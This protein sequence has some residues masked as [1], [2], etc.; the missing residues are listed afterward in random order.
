MKKLLLILLIIFVPTT[1]FGAKV[2]IT[3]FEWQTVV[4]DQ[5]FTG[6]ADTPAISTATFNG[7]LASLRFLTLS[8]GTGRYMQQQFRAADAD[9]AFVKFA[10]RIVTAPSAATRIANIQQNASPF[11]Q[12]V[13]LRLNT[14]RTLTLQDE[15]G[16]VGSSAALALD[17]WYT[18]E[19][20]MDASGVASTDIVELRINESVSVTSSLRNLSAGTAFVAIGGNIG[21][22]AATT[23]EWFVDDIVIDNASYPGISKVVIVKPTGAGDNACTT[24][25]FDFINEVPP[26]TTATSGSTMCELDANPTNG[27]FNVTNSSTAGIDS[28]DTISAVSVFGFVREET[29]GTSNYTLRLK[30][31]SGA[32]VSSSGSVDAGNATPRT[33]PSGAVSFLNNLISVTDPTTGIAW[34]P[35]GT[36]SIDNMQIGVGTT[37]GTPDDWVLTLAAMVEY[38]EGVAVGNTAIGTPNFIIWGMII[39]NGLLQL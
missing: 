27:D 32:T 14:D 29:A 3:G 24:G 15:D 34:T 23:A 28:Y 21:G 17:T 33:N 6:V 20:K 8:S 26:S 25:T 31:A 1:V 16:D 30:S 22:E 4:V 35:T 9:L 37:D 11:T 7:G 39:L 5:E 13:R 10:L 38:K 19:L 18:I 2:Y 36:N 12:I